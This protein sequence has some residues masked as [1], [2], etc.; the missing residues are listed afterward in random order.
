MIADC[1]LGIAERKGDSLRLAGAVMSADDF[2]KHT[3]QP[4]IRIVR[5]VEALPKLMRRVSSQNSYCVLVL[6]LAQ[7][8]ARQRALDR[9]QILLPKWESLKKNVM[10]RF[11]GLTC[12]SNSS[13]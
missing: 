12:S 10:N 2:R 8:I 11:T 13:L 5:L 6:L 3:F 7:T 4:G 9:G 1:G